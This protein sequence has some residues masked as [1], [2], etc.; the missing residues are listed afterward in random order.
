MKPISCNQEWEESRGRQ[1]QKDFCAREPHWVLFD[2]S[3]AR[4][5]ERLWREWPPI[6]VFLPGKSHGQRSLAGYSPWVPKSR[7]RL[8][9]FTFTFTFFI[10]VKMLLESLQKGGRSIIETL[11]EV[12][13]KLRNNPRTF[14][15]IL[16][17]PTSSNMANE[18]GLQGNLPASVH[19]G[20]LPV[21]RC[22]T[23]APVTSSRVQGCEGCKRQ[24]VAETAV[25]GGPFLGP[26]CGTC[27]TLRNE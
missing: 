8:R 15:Q 1:S 2:S 9:N 27:L 14:W 6:P 16:C 19:P 25:E 21:C 17:F 13:R 7:T 3:V 4:A 22:Q 23:G 10:H 26:K 20:P 5:W 24:G 11:T 12:P 18:D